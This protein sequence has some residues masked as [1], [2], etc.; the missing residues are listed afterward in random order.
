MGC[1]VRAPRKPFCNARMNRTGSGGMD[2]VLICHFR[3]GKNYIAP[4]CSTKRRGFAR[5]VSNFEALPI[6]DKERVPVEAHNTALNLA[7]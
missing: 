1:N 4:Q 5:V 7:A 6:V 3:Y 2:T